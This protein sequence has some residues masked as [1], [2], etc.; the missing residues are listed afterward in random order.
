[1]G[2]QQEDIKVGLDEYPTSKDVSILRFYRIPFDPACRQI[3]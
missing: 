3:R 2:V 1:M